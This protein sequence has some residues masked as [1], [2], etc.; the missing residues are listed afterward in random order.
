[1]PA[2]ALTLPPLRRLAPCLQKIGA[3]TAWDTTTGSAEVGVCMIDSGA[4]TTHED[5]AANIKGGWNT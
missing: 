1:M 3:P 5:L 4:R 2:S